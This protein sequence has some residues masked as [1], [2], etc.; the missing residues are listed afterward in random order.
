MLA[1]P[2]EKE[3]D[4]MQN[5]RILT[6]ALIA[7]L[8]LGPCLAWANHNNVTVAVTQVTNLPRDR[9]LLTGSVS[10]QNTTS[11]AQTGLLTLTILEPDATGAVTE[12]YHTDLRTVDLPATS[13]ATV[14]VNFNVVVPR[15]GFF[16]VLADYASSIGGNPVPHT[17]G[18][19]LRVNA[20]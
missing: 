8:L 10:V 18:S 15:P 5:K 16:I 6:S 1:G 12:V 3:G 9:R 20:Q 14:R 13:G 7:L 2:H 19:A 17:H 11:N 4:A